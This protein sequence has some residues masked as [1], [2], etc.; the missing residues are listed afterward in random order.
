VTPEERAQRILYRAKDTPNEYG[1]WDS[2]FHS[3]LSRGGS[4]E[5]QNPPV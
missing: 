4:D 3:I 5:S 1:T 2:L